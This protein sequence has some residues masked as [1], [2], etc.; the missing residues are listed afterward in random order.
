MGSSSNG[1]VHNVE[2]FV[3]CKYI[4]KKWLELCAYT[5]DWGWHFMGSIHSMP[6]NMARGVAKLKPPSMVGANFYFFY[7]GLHN[8]RQGA[9]HI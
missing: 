8:S 7:V 2:N 1:M 4:D 5:L 6:F 9:M 3:T